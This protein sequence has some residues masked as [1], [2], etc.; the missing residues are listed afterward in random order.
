MALYVKGFI[1]LFVVLTVLLHLP[2][3]ENYR[4]YIR[5]FSELILTMALLSPVLSV[6]CDS[7]EFLELIA[8]EAF[9]EELSMVSEDMQHIQY[10]YADYHKEAYEDAIGEDVKRIAEGYHFKV[11]EVAVKL[12]EDYVVEYITL[13]ISEDDAEQV[14]IEQ[15]NV[16]REERAADEEPVNGK[17]LKAELMTYYQLEEGEIEIRYGKG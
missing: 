7:D 12:S 17:G 15:V 13:R 1:V 5:F 10:L 4:K 2:P 16:M 9:A 11:Q 6:F 8:Y 3:Q 14:V